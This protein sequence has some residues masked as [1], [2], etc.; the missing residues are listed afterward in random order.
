MPVIFTPVGALNAI[1]SLLFAVLS[2]W[3]V[4]KFGASPEIGN[5]TFLVVGLCVSGI[6]QFAIGGKI[7]FVPVALIWGLVL[8]VSVCQ[9]LAPEGRDGMDVF[10]AMAGPCLLLLF[11]IY[12]KVAYSRK[13]S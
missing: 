11:W 12:P 13:A 1:V 7:Y 6:L 10:L 5:G 8:V 4:V 3:L 9:K 2:K